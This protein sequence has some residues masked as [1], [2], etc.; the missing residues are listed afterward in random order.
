M[1]KKLVSTLLVAAMLAGT[2][3]GCG[4]TEESG[5]AAAG[6]SSASGTESTTET[7]TADDEEKAASGEKI[8]VTVWSDNRADYDYMQGKLEEFNS[9]NDHIEID[10]QVYTDNYKQA[11]ELAFD[12]GEGPDV[13]GQGQGALDLG[14]NGQAV[15]VGPLLSDEIKELYGEELLNYGRNPLNY[16]QIISL[17]LSSG[18]CRL[19]YNKDIFERCGLEKAPETYAEVVEY[20]KIITDTLSDEG[21]YGFAMN[22][23]SASSA[24]GRSLMPCT[25]LNRGTQTGVN[26]ITGEYEWESYIPA[27]DM[28]KQMYDDGSMYPGCDQLDIDPLRTEF[29]AGKIGMYM[30]YSSAEPGV[31]TTQFPTEENWDFAVLPAEETAGEY[32]SKNGGIECASWLIS[33]DCKDLDAALEVFE[34]LYSYDVQ[35][36]RYENGLSISPVSAIAESCEPELIKEHPLMAIQEKTDTYW[37]TIA[38]GVTPE[39]ED[40]SSMF[41]GYILGIPGYEDIDAICE[42]LNTRYTEALNRGLTDG[43]AS[44]TIYPDMDLRNPTAAEPVSVT[45]PIE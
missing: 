24:L 19:V 1:K 36:G 5:S 25:S 31:Y 14:R 21:I 11:V 9:T 34:W 20:A 45:E 16:D 43:T 15:D 32:T 10:Y 13:F 17:P 38:S 28:F 2:L 6:G 18:A 39:G 27:L 42:E 41:S 12:T 23:K 37:P 29:A 35:S 44:L 33:K 8:V 3:A 4:E 40:W 22:L 30:S 7:K 26:P